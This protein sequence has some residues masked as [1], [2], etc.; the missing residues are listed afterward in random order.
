MPLTFKRFYETIKPSMN[1]PNTMSFE[2]FDKKEKNGL[3][4]EPR[5]SLTRNLNRAASPNLTKHLKEINRLN[6]P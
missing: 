1:C 2:W 6:S 4:E 3:F 5:I